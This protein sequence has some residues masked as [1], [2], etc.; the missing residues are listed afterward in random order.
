MALDARIS[1]ST[2]SRTTRDIPSF[3]I[4]FL[5]FYFSLWHFACCWSLCDCFF[6]SLSRVWLVFAIGQL[7]IPHTKTNT[8]GILW[9]NT[10]YLLGRNGFR[11]VY[12]YSAFWDLLFCLNFDRMNSV[13]NWMGTGREKKIIR[14]SI[15]KFVANG[16]RHDLCIASVAANNV[17]A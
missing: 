9:I 2:R 10:R 16:M 11:C 7:G 15:W 17:Y 13:F 14:S 5:F 6:I 12:L 4:L 8:H 3:P 1:K